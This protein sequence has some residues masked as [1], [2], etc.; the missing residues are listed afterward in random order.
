MGGASMDEGDNPVGI[1]VTPL[2]D[3]IF[4]LC[5]FFM[6]SFKFKQIEGKFD[7][8]LPKGKGAEG[9]PVGT[10]MPKEIRVAIL[11]DEA[12]QQSIRKYGVTKLTPEQ[13]EQL[14]QLINDQWQDFKRLN[15]VD[16]PLTIDAD[17]RVPWKDVINVINLGKRC[18][19][20]KVE[21][22]FGAPPA[23]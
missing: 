7:A 2:V 3:I 6:I 19:V 23:K 15:E 20:E 10:V 22:A 4:C 18:G 13:D 17:M 21:F 1:N 8:W 14:Q 5:V 12:N 9:M 16:V 11:W